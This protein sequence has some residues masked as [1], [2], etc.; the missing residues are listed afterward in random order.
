MV[1]IPSVVFLLLLLGLQLADPGLVVEPLSRFRDGRWAAAGYALFVLLFLVGVGQVWA[2]ARLGRQ[3]EIVVPVVALGLL[4][5]VALT[6]SFDTDHGVASALLMGLVFGW[7]LV[8]L[9]AAGSGWAFVH[10]AVPVV[11]LVAVAV[12]RS[13]GVWQKGLIV[14]YVLAVNLDCLAA[15]PRPERRKRRRKTGVYAPRVVW[16]RYDGPGRPDQ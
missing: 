13:Y 6:P 9:A 7:Y 15:L 11:L 8:R 14:Y 12:G 16:R 10:G 1:L 2:Y 3:R 4:G 5:V